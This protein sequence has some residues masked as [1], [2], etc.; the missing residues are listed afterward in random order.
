[1]NHSFKIIKRIALSLCIL[2]LNMHA[3]NAAPFVYVN[4]AN[5]IQV[6]D[7]ATNNLIA[8]LTPTSVV[9][10]TFLTAIAVAPFNTTNTACA[11][12]EGN[13]VSPAIFYSIDTTTNTFIN[14]S[15]GT[16]L[17]PVDPFQS[18]APLCIAYSVDG[19]TVYIAGVIY[20]GGPQS[21][22]YKI[23]PITSAS[24]TQTQFVLPLAS[25]IIAGMVVGNTPLGEKIYTFSAD[26]RHV[27]ATDPGTLTSTTIF[28]TGGHIAA[29]ALA[30]DGLTLYVIQDD[31]TLYIYDI[32]SATVTS[33]SLG[34]TGIVALVISP[35]NDYLYASSA[36]STYAIPIPSLA[37]ITN[38]SPTLNS[39]A[40]AIN[41][42]GSELFINGVSGPSNN[43]EVLSF[44]APGGASSNVN[45]SFG[46]NNNISK[47][48]IAVTQDPIIPPTPPPSPYAT[49]LPP[50]SVSGCKTKNVFLL[51][52]DYIN[53]ITWTTPAYG[54]EP[55]SYNI[56]R[57]AA[58]TQL[59]AT[60]SASST[61]KFYDHDRNPNVIYSYYI[62]T[63]DGY[64]NESDAAS[65]TVTSSC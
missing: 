39:S 4:T 26:T 45:Q 29:L 31:G 62:T 61:L 10:G 15:L 57:D 43:Q 3:L 58:L 50:A 28:S 44:L 25:D 60:V 6:I 33:Q 47:N 2:L 24:P 53:K 54:D 59:A 37:P 23:S 49:I 19:T 52:T 17:I 27:Y 42:N 32:M 12:K 56:Y 35:N 51:Q 8:T 22:A 30:P 11:V 21:L 20:S 18:N 65:M 5:T 38:F 46:T 55:V 9:G 13:G 7:V 1:M 40:T 36:S 14:T 48:S 64:G 63:V 16:A 41:S 34:I